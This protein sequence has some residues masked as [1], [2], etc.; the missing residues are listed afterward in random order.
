MAIKIIKKV[1]TN[2]TLKSE[3]LEDGVFYESNTG[4][5]FLGQRLPDYPELRAVGVNNDEYVTKEE[6]DPMLF[7][8]VDATIIY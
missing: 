2:Y 1:P 3:E 4:L 5:L 8:K 6:G 7:R